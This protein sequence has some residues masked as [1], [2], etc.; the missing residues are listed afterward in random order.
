[1]LSGRDR[2]RLLAIVVLQLFANLLDLVGIAL[3]GLVAVIGTASISGNSGNSPAIPGLGVLTSRIQNDPTS[4]LFLAITAGALLIGKSLF[5]A[6]MTRHVLHFLAQRQV[7]VSGKMTSELMTREVSVVELESTHNTSFAITT[8]VYALLVR[9]LGSSVQ[10][11]SDA[12]LLVVLAV[13]MSFIDPVLTFLTIGFLTIVGIALHRILGGWAARMGRTA[14]MAEI[15]VRER[16]DEAIKDFRWIRATS[17]SKLEVAAITREANQASRAFADTYFANQIPKYVF[18]G[19]MVIGGGLLAMFL[20]STRTYPQ[21]IGGV[22]LFLAISAR[23]TPSLLRIQGSLIDIRSADGPAQSAIQ[24]E[25]LLTQTRTP[26]KLTGT[27]RVSLKQFALLNPAPPRIEMQNVNFAYRGAEQ[28]SVSLNDFEV[29]AGSVVA[30]VGATGSGKS[31]LADLSLGL[32]IPNSGSVWID[33]QTPEEYLARNPNRVAYVPQDPGIVR[34]TVRDNITMRKSTSD[35]LDDEIWKVLKQVRLDKFLRDS[36]DGLDTLVGASGVRL[37]G[38][39]KQ[40]LGLARALH[41]RPLLLVL[42]EA[43]SALDGETET[44][45]VEA[46][47]GLG[48]SVTRVI[49][50]HRLASIMNADQIYYMEHGRIMGK[51]NFQEL[52]ELLPQ[53]DRQVK[54]LGM[55]SSN[56]DSEARVVEPD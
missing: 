29:E 5:T 38:G 30:L 23:V 46:L 40:R 7:S 22:V 56:S 28:F 2:R 17:T 13:G 55:S 27:D 26:T 42:D 31:T 51:G 39:Q 32:L 14:A 16:V 1:M 48:N 47:D 34:G 54:L 37:S 19:A 43:T 20:F 12:G 50:A 45:I 10:L 18:E 6:F 33:D 49:I 53:F 21:A 9:V 44:A 35:E 8:G 11:L 15:A 36:R 41:L 4:L 3:L 52:C 25:Q 24:L